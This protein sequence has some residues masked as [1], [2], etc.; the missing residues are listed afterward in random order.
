MHRR[1]ARRCRSA[2]VKGHFTHE[3]L[4]SAPGRPHVH[5]QPQRRFRVASRSP[6]GRTPAMYGHE[7]SDG[8]IV[9]WK[10]PNKA[11]LAAAEEVEERRPVEG[12]MAGKARTGRIAGCPVSQASCHVRTGLYPRAMCREPRCAKTRDR[13]PVRESRTPG[14]ARGAASNRRPYRDCG[15][16]GE[17]SAFSGQPK[18]E[19]RAL[20]A[21]S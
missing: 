16:V 1:Y 2:V 9:P 6:D 12:N 20:N 13:S 8:C 14:S 3:V 10:P 11:A 18:A 21:D 4:P 19:C 7:E 15:N 17:L 5:P